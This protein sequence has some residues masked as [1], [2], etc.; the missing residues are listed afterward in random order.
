MKHYFHFAEYWFKKYY[1][2]KSVNFCYHLLR[3]S[4]VYN[5]RSYDVR[6]R[7]MYLLA[8]NVIGHRDSQR[9]MQD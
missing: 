6:T 1:I 4:I 2:G 8:I 5:F 3:E 9:W 7:E